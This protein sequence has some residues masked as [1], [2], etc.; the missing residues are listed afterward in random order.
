[1]KIF[2]EQR[3]RF[4]SGRWNFVDD[5]DVFVGYDSE[6]DCCEHASYY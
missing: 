2:N 3:G 6:Q 5:N 4:W 1:M